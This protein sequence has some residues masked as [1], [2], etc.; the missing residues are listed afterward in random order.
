MRYHLRTLLILL[1]FGPPVLA[2]MVMVAGGAALDPLVLGAAAYI[3]LI[4]VLLGMSKASEANPYYE[5]QVETYDR[6]TKEQDRQLAEQAEAM[7]RN[8]VLRARQ[9]ANSRRMEQLLDKWE[10]QARRQDAI[11]MAQEQQLGL[12]S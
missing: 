6:Q 11:L 3:G 2:A 1:A 9:E 8:E 7:R 12:K 4:A 10:E 5:A